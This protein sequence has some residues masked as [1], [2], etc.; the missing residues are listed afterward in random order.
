MHYYAQS[1]KLAF[2]CLN[3]VCAG[4]RGVSPLRWSLN[5]T[6]LISWCEKVLGHSL[7]QES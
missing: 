6:R 7:V 3:G 2:N 4:E 1:L 5:K